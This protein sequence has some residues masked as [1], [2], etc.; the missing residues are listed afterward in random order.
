MKE[1]I[2]ENT[3]H[4]QSEVRFKRMYGIFMVFFILGLFIV[5]SILWTQYGPK[6]SDY[7]S[8]A[9]KLVYVMDTVEA[10]RGN[11]LAADGRVL[12]TSVPMY[13]FRMDF[14]SDGIIDTLFYNPRTKRDYVPELADSLSRMFGDRSAAQYE[15]YIRG[16]MQNPRKNR[17]AKIIPR[18]VNYTEMSRLMKFPIWENG[19]RRS[20]LIVIQSTRRILPHGS[21]ASRTIGN[22]NVFEKG[23]GLE[24]SFNEELKG[25]PGWSKM[26]KVSG[27][28]RV[29]EPDEHNTEP[30]NGVDVVTTIDVDI[31]DVADASLRRQIMEQQADWGTAILMEVETGKILA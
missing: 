7:R 23:S 31:Q 16:C 29:P 14:A 17:Y 3:Q 4:E 10:Q 22:V 25:K 20:G 24:M 26:R 19:R 12:A 6:S 5:I 21:M 15:Q 8:A 28:F 1:K 13:E 2:V 11:I 27:S 30:V 18:K 9:D